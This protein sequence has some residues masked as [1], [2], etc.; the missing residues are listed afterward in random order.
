MFTFTVGSVEEFG[1]RMCLN[2]LRSSADLFR[3][4][5]VPDWSLLLIAALL[6]IISFRQQRYTHPRCLVLCL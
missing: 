1:F 6:A 3:W 5:R 2:V 4:H